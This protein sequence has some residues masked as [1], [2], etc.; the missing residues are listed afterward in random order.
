MSW[1]WEIAIQFDSGAAHIMWHY[2]YVNRDSAL[3][4]SKDC[5]SPPD[6]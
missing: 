1:W 6:I 4:K 3:T 2:V 5:V